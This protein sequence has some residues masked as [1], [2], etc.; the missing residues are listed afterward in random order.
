MATNSVLIHLSATSTNDLNACAS[1]F[2][3]RSFDSGSYTEFGVKLASFFTRFKIVK[4]ETNS[5]WKSESEYW[6]DKLSTVKNYGQL[7]AQFVSWLRASEKEPIELMKADCRN[8]GAI[9]T[10]TFSVVKELNII[11]MSARCLLHDPIYEVDFPPFDG[12]PEQFLKMYDVDAKD[13]TKYNPI[14]IPELDRSDLLTI[15]ELINTNMSQEACQFEKICITKRLLTDCKNEIDQMFCG[16]NKIPCGD[17]QIDKI[18]S[19]LQQLRLLM[20]NG[21]YKTDMSNNNQ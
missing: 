19:V 3:S 21:T 6:N 10:Y 8:T 4:K 16:D 5:I 11:K 17:F 1:I 9:F 14:T 2:Q 13:D 12:L 18:A 15:S 7:F 20:N